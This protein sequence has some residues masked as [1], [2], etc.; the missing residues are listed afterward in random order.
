MKSVRT[1]QFD[2]LFDGLPAD[3]QGDATEAYKQFASDPAYPGLRLEPVHG[4]RGQGYYSARVD[5]HYRSLAKRLPDTWLWFWIGS[6]AEY[7]KLL[8]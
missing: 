2:K 4:R 8:Q 1:R 6:H 3:V 7:D 5:S